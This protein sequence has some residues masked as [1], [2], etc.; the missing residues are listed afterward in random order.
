MSN[1][2]DSGDKSFFSQMFASVDKRMDRIDR[3][4]EK[5]RVEVKSH[6]DKTC[7]ELGEVKDAILKKKVKEEIDIKNE[8][9][10]FLQSINRPQWIVAGGSAVMMVIAVIMFL[11]A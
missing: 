7:K 9:R 3:E 8:N 11:S 2:M 1:N 5:N 10:R 6:L 4:I